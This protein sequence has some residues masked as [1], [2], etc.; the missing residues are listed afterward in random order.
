MVA[1]LA[2]GT[3]TFGGE[4]F[5]APVIAAA[6]AEPRTAGKVIDFIDGATPIEE[7]IRPLL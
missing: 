6:L 2:L 7:A 4:R 3:T 1:P 5:Y